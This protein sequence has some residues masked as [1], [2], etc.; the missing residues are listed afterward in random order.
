VL[1]AVSLAHCLLL[2]DAGATA[3]SL[4]GVYQIVSV[5]ERGT[6]TATDGTPE[7][8]AVPSALHWIPQANR[9]RR[10]R[11]SCFRGQRGEGRVLLSSNTYVLEHDRLATK[12]F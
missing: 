11:V 6:G 9:H 3:F 7:W 10:V 5:L 2:A 12:Q 8:A 4:C 1:G